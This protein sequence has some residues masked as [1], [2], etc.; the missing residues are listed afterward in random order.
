[1]LNKKGSL[2]KPM[3]VFKQ[4]ELGNCSLQNWDISHGMTQKARNISVF[5]RVF[6]WQNRTEALTNNE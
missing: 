6:P 5:F 1:M 3:E 2:S 4:W